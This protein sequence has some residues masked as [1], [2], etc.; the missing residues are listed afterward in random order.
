MPVARKASPQARRAVVIGLFGLATTL[1]LMILMLRLAGTSTELDVRLGD[2]DFRGIDALALAT[3]IS[4]NGPVA[5]PDLVGGGRPIWITHLGDDPAT[6]WASFFARVPEKNIDCLAQWETSSQEFVDSC[7]SDNR[8]GS[9]GTGLEQ[10]T[11]RVLG[12]ELR[13]EINDLSGTEQ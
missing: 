1:G 7:D 12:N 5:F 3:E 4:D 13:I 10:L 6:G 8:F 2:D 11:W 9:Q